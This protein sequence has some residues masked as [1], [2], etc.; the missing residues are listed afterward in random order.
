[1]EYNKSLTVLEELFG[2]D[3][4]FVLATTKDNVPSTRV[5]DTYY[6]NGVFWVVTYATTK[7][8]IELSENPSVAL[9]NNFFNFKGKAYNTGHPLDENNKEIRE[10]LMRVF[11]PWYLAHN[12]END[13]HMCYVKIEPESGFFHKDGT[14]YDVDF[15]QKTAKTITF[16]PDMDL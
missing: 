9:C 1:M 14:G 5:V 2:K 8:V 4:T 7:K 12:N 13:K 6:E 10:K 11:E 16:A 15:I 3:C